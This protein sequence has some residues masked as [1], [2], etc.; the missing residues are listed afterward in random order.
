MNTKLKFAYGYVL[1]IISLIVIAYLVFVGMLYLMGG[2]FIPTLLIT[3]GLLLLL[4]ISCVALQR[5]KGTDRKFN[6]RING[7]RVLLPLMGVLCLVTMVPFTHFFTIHKHEQEITTE[8]TAMIDKSK[9]MLNEFKTVSKE[10]VI[11][12]NKNLKRLLRSDADKRKVTGGNEFLQKVPREILRENMIHI[13]ETQLGTGEN[14]DSLR[15]GASAWLDDARR[16]VTVWNVFLLGNVNKIREAIDL[17][18]EQMVESSK[19]LFP[20]EKTGKGM[21]H[22]FASEHIDEIHQHLSNIDN[23]STRLAFPG[24]LALLAGLVCMSLLF[25]PYYLQQRHT[26]SRV[27]LFGKGHHKSGDADHDYD[28]IHHIRLISE[29]SIPRHMFEPQPQSRL[30][31]LRTYIT[32]SE[33]PFET[34]TELLNNGSLTTEELLELLHND[35]NMLDAATVSQCLEKGVFTR[36]QLLEGHEYLEGFVNM[37]GTPM[38]DLL[39]VDK[40]IDYLDEGCTE[41]YFWGI[42]SSGKTCAL[43]VLMDAAMENTV[44]NDL[45]VKGDCQGYDYMLELINVFRGRDTYCVLPGRTPVDANFA[46]RLNLTDYRDHVHPV[47]LIDMA[48]ELFCYLYWRYNNIIDNLNI[49]HETAFQSFENIL[50]GY[51]TTNRKFHFFIIEYGTEKKRYKGFTQDEYLTFGLE[52]LEQTGVLRDATDG[53]CVIVTKYDHLFTR[54]GEDED[55]NNHLSAYLY[56]NYG[57][58]LRKLEEYC[59][60]YDIAGG[61]LPDPVPFCI[62]DVC[63]KNYCR[64]STDYAKDILKIIVRESVG[65]RRDP[66]ARI[67]DGLRK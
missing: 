26:R 15:M 34:V 56:R 50:Q 35:C 51:R 13:M 61:R 60:K 12:Y 59:R 22:V 1:A 44:I 9:L 42:P 54:I 63:F 19:L 33:R 65:F 37:L 29:V 4:T 67:E 21:D 32:D 41:F 48:G 27:S 36:E 57:G 45:T 30:D 49:H 16:G 66:I 28:N 24:P 46:I 8:F 43:G 3:C 17:W 18:N 53:V 38:T 7:E 14:D 31:Q 62:G 55:V 5:L 11:N 58:F 40:H 25:L 20:G 52:Y 23:V 47:T 64:I 10:R 6:K 2:K 39:P